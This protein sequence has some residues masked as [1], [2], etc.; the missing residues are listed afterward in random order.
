MSKRETLRT[1]VLI[2]ANDRLGEQIHLRVFQLAKQ[3]E[4]P[5]PHVEE[6][7]IDLTVNSLIGNSTV[8]TTISPIARALKF[9]P[10]TWE[11]AVRMRSKI[12]A[13]FVGS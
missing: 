8:E 6:E 1:W 3:F 12:T 9:W 11:Y 5:Q 2:R 10:A 7:L 13:R 4:M